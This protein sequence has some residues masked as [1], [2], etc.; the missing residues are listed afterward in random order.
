MSSGAA[1]HNFYELWLGIG[2]SSRPD[3]Y[4]LLGISPFEKDEHKILA[5][6]DARRDQLRHISP[7]QFVEQWRK[8]AD[9][10]IAAK[11]CLLTPAARLAYDEHLRYARPDRLSKP[12]DD[13]EL[14]F[15][16]E[17]PP[18]TA[19][20]P[21]SASAMPQVEVVTP[22]IELSHLSSDDEIVLGAVPELP[23]VAGETAAFTSPWRGGTTGS[24]P[25]FQGA[26]G[27]AQAAFRHPPGSPA[28]M[29]ASPRPS[30]ALEKI[31][32]SRRQFQRNVIVYS[33]LFG[34]GAM[35]ALV[36]VAML[37]DQQAKQAIHRGVAQPS[38]IGAE[39]RSTPMTGASQQ[40][41][42]GVDT[43]K[44][45]QRPARS[46]FDPSDRATAPMPS[47]I[48]SSATKASELPSVASQQILQ[49]R[50][51]L[52][53]I[54]TALKSRSFDEATKQLEIAE[55][56]ASGPAQEQQAALFRQLVHYVENFWQAVRT[57]AATLHGGDELMRRGKPIAI[58]VE[59]KSD[60]LIIRAD[61]KNH[62][63][64]IPG[65]L[66]ARV[67]V[68]IAER[69]IRDPTQENLALGAFYATDAAGDL[70]MAEDLWKSAGDEL[71]PLLE[72]LK[73]ES[74]A[75]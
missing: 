70:S 26:T 62:T 18:T 49:F 43:S 27:A 11:R 23:P 13:E 39:K 32:K 75:K 51:A 60:Q 5:A 52:Q 24:S 3:H 41:P 63:Y 1:K 7:G 56:M 44:P 4:Q 71:S 21:A 59:S 68:A 22:P 28:A 55:K 8:L 73:L 50:L 30:G 47:P 74:A 37:Q 29:I 6:F 38:A 53:S 17:L 36:L 34:G 45:Q 57:G 72:L 69:T 9:E 67:A 48:E 61:G 42:A 10:I 64:T 58:V 54:R 19:G 35:I 14:T 16:D 65:N 2:C 12:A 20:P 25:E 40:P 31:E 46:P 66:D 33:L 15:A